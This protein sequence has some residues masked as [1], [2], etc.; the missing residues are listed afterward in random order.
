MREQ[1]FSATQPLYKR[2]IYGAHKLPD[3]NP[4]LAALAADAGGLSQA[5]LEAIGLRLGPSER[6]LYE[7]L[8]DNGPRNTIQIR[9]DCAIGNVSNARILLNQ[10]LEEAGVSWRCVCDVGPLT[11]RFGERGRI[12]T[13]VLVESDEGLA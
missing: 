10:K 12:G 11:N 2:K 9:R 4:L 8:R 1:G 13:L 7:Y 6:R 3:E 5:Q